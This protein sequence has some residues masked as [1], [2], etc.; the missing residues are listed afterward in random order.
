M[1]GCRSGSSTEMLSNRIFK[2][3]S[4]DAVDPFDSAWSDALVDRFECPSHCEIVFQLD[5]YDLVSK[6]LEE[7]G[8]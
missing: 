1:C 6:G 8:W 3:L 7:P 2:N 4:S 5:R